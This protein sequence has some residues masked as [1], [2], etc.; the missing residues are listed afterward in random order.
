MNPWTIR[1]SHCGHFVG[2]FTGSP[3]FDLDCLIPGC[4][5]LVPLAL[6]VWLPIKSRRH[7]WTKGQAD[8]QAKSARSA[9]TAG[10]V[11]IL[12]RKEPTMNSC[13]RLAAA[14]VGLLLA[15]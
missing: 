12:T 11:P 9:L 2:S 13:H 10:L 8:F 4:T 6:A 7:H 1:P 3:P 5:S 15:A 14:V